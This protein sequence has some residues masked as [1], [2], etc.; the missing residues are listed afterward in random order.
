[1]RYLAGQTASMKWST[2]R[3]VSTASMVTVVLRHSYRKRKKCVSER[4]GFR[5]PEGKNER[6]RDKGCHSTFS[7]N[8]GSLSLSTDRGGAESSSAL[9]EI[10]V[11]WEGT[12]MDK[13]DRG[14]GARIF[15]WRE[16]RS[17]CVRTRGARYTG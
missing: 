15:I 10:E 13:V 9:L 4:D 14:E 5:I 6:E 3:R 17:R 8:G 7:N 11:E 12:R 1:M 2:P 16:G